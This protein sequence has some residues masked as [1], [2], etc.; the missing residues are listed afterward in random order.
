M[1]SLLSPDCQR[2]LLSS[3]ML[4]VRIERED[5][6]QANREREKCCVSIWI[7]TLVI[8][9]IVSKFTG[10]DNCMG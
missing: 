2:S 6:E 9:L 8:D 4:G 7:S 1:V 5:A 3:G 10:I